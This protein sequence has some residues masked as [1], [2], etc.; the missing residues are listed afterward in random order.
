MRK[1]LS[2]CKIHATTVAASLLLAIGLLLAALAGAAVAVEN[3]YRDP[4]PRIN[5]LT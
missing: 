2:L 3:A 1:T 4:T 5:P